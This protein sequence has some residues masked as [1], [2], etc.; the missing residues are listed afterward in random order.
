[1]YQGISDVQA[2][3]GISSSFSVK[4]GE[5]IPVCNPLPYIFSGLVSLLHIQIVFVPFSLVF[6][7][8]IISHCF[9]LITISLFSLFPLFRV[10]FKQWIS[11]FSEHI[12]L[13][14]LLIMHNSRS[15]TKYKEENKGHLR[16][17]QAEITI[18]FV[19]LLF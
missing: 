2:V 10:I 14:I 4:R 16:S 8:I 3:L 11:A 13:K 17:H 5:V 15:I 18:K 19:R 7:R 9:I 1:M 6:L 12:F